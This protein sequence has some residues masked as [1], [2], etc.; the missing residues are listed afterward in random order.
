M[1]P[2]KD[3]FNGTLVPMVEALRTGL[4]NNLLSGVLIGSR[5]RGEGDPEGDRDPLV[6]API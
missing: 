6:I 3:V 5:A 2:S 1:S 4:G